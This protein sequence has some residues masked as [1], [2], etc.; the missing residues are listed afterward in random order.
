MYGYDMASRVL[1][2]GVK[3]YVNKSSA[4]RT[5]S[6]A[7]QAVVK[8]KV[9]IDDNGGQSIIDHF[10]RGANP[11]DILSN[12]EFEVLMFILHEKSAG[13]IAEIICL[14]PKTIH[15]HKDHIY[16]KL[17]V[18][19]MVGLTRLAVSHGLLDSM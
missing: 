17:G 4:S 5:L 8:G 16:K 2:L 9:F 15:A 12:R 18:S 13:E 10:Q 14:S 6:K 19:N 7:V 11:F 1:Q 3:G